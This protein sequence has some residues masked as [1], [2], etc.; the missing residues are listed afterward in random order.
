MSRAKGIIAISETVREQLTSAVKT[1]ARIEVI[2][3]GHETFTEN[4]ERPPRMQANHF[5]L[6]LASDAPHKRL[7]DVALA[8]SISGP[9]AVLVI[10][11]NVSPSRRAALRKLAAGAE[12]EFLGFVTRRQEVAWLL[13]NA[14]CAISASSVEA[15]PLPLVEGAECGCPLILSDIP[16]H[17]EVAGDHASY[18]AVGDHV[19]LSGLIDSHLRQHGHREPWSWDVSWQQ[20]SERVADVLRWAAKE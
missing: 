2:H 12:L 1:Q 9:K 18:F 8:F 16:V 17:R 19:N 4:S 10:A 14:S 11:G 5:V 20:H 7:D 15:F 6:A 13:Q 3:S